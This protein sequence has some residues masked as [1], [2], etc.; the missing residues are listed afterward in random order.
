MRPLKHNILNFLARFFQYLQIS[1]CSLNKRENIQ[2]LMQF[3]IW[4]FF[5][6]YIFRW[7]KSPLFS[8]YAGDDFAGGCRQINRD[9][10]QNNYR[11]QGSN[12]EMYR[13]LIELST[14]KT[15]WI[16]HYHSQNGYDCIDICIHS[17][18]LKI[19]SYICTTRE[20]ISACFL[21]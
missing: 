8:C 11:M 19:P 13:I 9:E 20:S 7:I 18:I 6:K 21:V 1:V 4:F 5:S 12:F 2:Y 10:I 16:F 3:L 15:A 17:F 14:S